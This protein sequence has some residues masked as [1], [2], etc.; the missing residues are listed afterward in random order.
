MESLSLYGRSALDGFAPPNHRY[1]VAKKCH[2]EGRPLPFGADQVIRRLAQFL[3]ARSS[4][5]NSKSISRLSREYPDFLDAFSLR[6]RKYREERGIIEAY[7]FAE[8]DSASIASRI[9]LQAQAI[10]TFSDVFFDLKGVLKNPIRTHQLVGSFDGRNDFDWDVSRL[11]KWVGY[12]LGTRGLD[13]MFGI[14]TRNNRNLANL[15]DVVAEQV[16][17]ML[18]LKQLAAMSRL[19]PNNAKHQEL[20]AKLWSQEQARREKEGASLN[21]Y[22]KH[23][24]AFLE[25]LPWTFGSD[26]EQLHAGTP[27][28]KYDMGAA[29]LRDAEVMRLSTGEAIDPD[30]PECLPPPRKRSPQAVAGAFTPDQVNPGSPSSTANR[31]VP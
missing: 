4:A 31:N 9:G 6:L 29:A 7:L 28:G 15:A 18:P 8:A 11:L 24:K 19:K 30:L 5:R 16:R 23:L 10:Q 2:D 20:L 13:E 17:T 21:P 27:L 26:A 22:E 3:R 1:R 14:S 25:E 12:K